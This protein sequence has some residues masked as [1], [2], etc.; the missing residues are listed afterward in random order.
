MSGDSNIGAWIQFARLTVAAGEMAPFPYI[1][2]VAGCIATILEVIEVRTVNRCCMILSG[3]LVSWQEQRGPSGL[4]REHWNDNTNH[5]GNLLKR[6]VIRVRLVFAGVC[7]ELQAYLEC[8]IAE[9]NTTRHNLKSK[10]IMRFLKTKKISSVIDGY[11]QRVNN[12]KAD[13]LVLVTTD[14][15]LAMSEMQNA[16]TQATETAQS[17]ITSTVKSQG[18]Y[19]RGEIRSLGDIQREHAAQICEKLQDLK[20]YY[21]GQVRELFPGDIY[22][23]KLVS[24][25]CDSSLGYEDRYGTVENSSTA[26]IIRVYQ[27]SPGNEEAILKRFDND[28]DTLIRTKHPNIAQVFGIC[29]SPNFPAIVFHGITQIPFRDYERNLTAKQFV[30]FYIQL[31]YELE[32]VSEYLS[33]HYTFLTPGFWAGRGHIHLNEHGQ[34]V[35]VAMVSEWY[36]TGGFVMRIFDK[37]GNRVR[38]RRLSTEPLPSHVNRW[39]LSLTLRKDNLCN[40]YDAIKR[41]ILSKPFQSFHPQ[42]Q[43]YAPGSVLTSR[44]ETLVGRVQTRLDEWNVHWTTSANDH[45]ILLLPS[46]N[47]GSITVPLPYA[48]TLPFD[49]SICSRSFNGALN[50][51]IAQASQL[52]SCVCSRGPVDD[53]ELLLIDTMFTLCVGLEERYDP[54]RL[55][56]T[57]MAEDHH[58]LSLSISAPSVDYQ[59]NKVSWPV[60][61]WFYDA[62][63]EM[64]LV[65]VEEVF[66]VK[67]FKEK[68]S[69]TPPVSKTVLT[70]IPELNAN[71]GFDPAR[72]GADVCKYFGWPFVEILDVSTGDW[73]PLHGTVPESTS[74]ISDDGYRTL[75]EKTAS[76][77]SN[78][79]EEGH[80]GEA[81]AETEVAP[82]LQTRSL[83]SGRG[84]WVFIVMF[85]IISIILLSFVVQTYM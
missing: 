71:Y 1:K 75:S 37:P 48:G 31:F 6:M 77:P 16:V 43:P 66:G 33:T 7:V 26:K 72:G 81:S 20:G 55:Y 56:N 62:G 65:E 83:K 18:H 34:V 12:I 84:S 35:V 52:Q 30:P 15:R 5:Q 73:M 76:S 78:A 45:T 80:V 21:K 28:A 3:G 51:W 57:F 64:S 13:Y 59:T 41:I 54:F 70:T 69:W 50:S 29:R 53:D 47:N 61:A 58:T 38:L 40:V 8:L 4:G 36:F 23:G 27:H 60:F 63:S 25:W 49:A 14:S 2:G 22:I 24:P 79:L 39:S 17:C 19:I 68:T 46:T 10:S 85:I 11:K 32:S 74:V 82:A 44:G 42:N 67:V 9:L